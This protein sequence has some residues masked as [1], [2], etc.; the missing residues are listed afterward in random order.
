M[1]ILLNKYFANKYNYIINILFINFICSLINPF[2][3]IFL[4]DKAA[5]LYHFNNL[6]IINFFLFVFFSII[7]L[8]KFFE[9]RFLFLK[10]KNNFIFIL[11]ALIIIIIVPIILIFGSIWVS[12]FVGDLN[13]IFNLFLAAVPDNPSLGATYQIDPSLLNENSSPIFQSGTGTIIAAAIILI[14][15]PLIIIVLIFSNLK[16]E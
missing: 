13:N 6:V 7:H 2:L 10:L 14:F 16:G 3:V 9:K 11:V 8:Y 12:L 5:F 1:V 4:Y 15:I